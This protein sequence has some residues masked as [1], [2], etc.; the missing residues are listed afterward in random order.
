M[1]TVIGKILIV[2]FVLGIMMGELYAQCYDFGRGNSGGR[3]D[4][5]LEVG[6]GLP[7]PITPSNDLRLGD[8]LKGE[9]G[10]RY[11]PIGS[12]FGLRVYYSYANLSDSGINQSE[13]H[14][15]KVAIHRGELQGIYLLDDLLGISWRSAIEV[16]SYIGIGAALGDPSG[17]DG[18][19][20]MIATTIGLRPRILID[21][22]RLH[23]YFNV[24]YG[25]LI[26]QQFDY[27][28]ESIPNT[29]KTNTESILQL[30]LGL[31]YRL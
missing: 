16:E 14:S 11:V 7:F 28:G 5:S 3:S 25:I 4:F 20:K 15:N 17:V 9:L 22:N 2:L 19:N 13:N 30:S 27:A 26:N 18:L 10:L 23:L 24:A 8:A 1:R 31:S 6:A 21:N 12:D 29:E